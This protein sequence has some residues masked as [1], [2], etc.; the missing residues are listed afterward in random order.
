MEAQEKSYS[1]IVMYTIHENATKLRSFIQQ[2]LEKEFEGVELDQSTYG[3]AIGGNL[4]S[5]VKRRLKKLCIDAVTN[6][7]GDGFASGDFVTLYYVDEAE[8]KGS[9]E[10]RITRSEIINI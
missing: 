1:G 7:S 9:K 3:I 5:D 10:W 6:N 2:G 4:I 8:I